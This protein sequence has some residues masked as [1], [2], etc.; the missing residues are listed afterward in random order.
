[1]DLL[2]AVGVQELNGLPHLGAADDAVVHKQQTLALDKL[3]DG[4]KLHFSHLVA[5]D[6]ILGHKASGPC[7]SVLYKGSGKRDTAPVGVSDSVRDT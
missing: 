2:C 5:H 4:D 1:M 6:L 3:M 7:G